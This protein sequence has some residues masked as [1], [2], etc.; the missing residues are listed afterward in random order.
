MRGGVA[1]EEEGVGV[2]LGLAGTVTSFEA[3]VPTLPEVSIAATVYVYAA[4]NATAVSVQSV[5]GAL[6]VATVE[7]L[8]CTR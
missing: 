6:T 5:V 1:D 7:P 8:R 4:P 3:A 2:G